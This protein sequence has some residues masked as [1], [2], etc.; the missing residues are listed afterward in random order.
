M[1]FKDYVDNCS[2]DELKAY[3]GIEPWM[4]ESLADLKRIKPKSG[5]GKD[6]I[7]FS[8]NKN[9]EEEEDSSVCLRYDAYLRHPDYDGRVGIMGVHWDEALDFEVVIEDGRTLFH[10]GLRKDT[11]DQFTG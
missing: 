3:P 1:K 11:A 4:E 7:H 10:T 5:D 6:S 9:T 8:E 2:W